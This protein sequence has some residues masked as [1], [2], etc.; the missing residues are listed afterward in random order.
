MIL[1]PFLCQECVLLMR[2]LPRRVAHRLSQPE[3]FIFKNCASKHAR[4]VGI[5]AGWP[6]MSLAVGQPFTMDV[7]WHHEGRERVTVRWVISKVTACFVVVQFSVTMKELTRLLFCSWRSH[8]FSQFFSEWILPPL[9]GFVTSLPTG[10]LHP[11]QLDGYT[12]A[13]WLITSLS[14][15]WLHPSC[16]CCTL[17]ENWLICPYSR[18]HFDPL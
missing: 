10:W 17:T 7:M 9:L 6:T 15:G 1:E 3:M 8:M 12:P 5:W 13:N 11:G 14:V 18:L 4:T 16:F 2:S